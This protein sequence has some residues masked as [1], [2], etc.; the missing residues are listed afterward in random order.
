MP[1]PSI[2]ALKREALEVFGVTLTDEQ[3]VACRGRL[4]TMLENVRLLQGWAGRLG[5]TA[6]AQIQRVIGPPSAGARDDD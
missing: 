2:E 1:K 3:A 4:P 5:E 6:P